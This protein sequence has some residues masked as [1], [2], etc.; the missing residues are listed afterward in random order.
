M[1]EF[2]P[3][4][5]QPANRIALTSQYTSGTDGYVFDGAD[6][7][8]MA[9]WE[10]ASNADT[11]EHEHPFDEYFIVVEGSYTVLLDGN[12]VHVGAGQECFIPRGSRVAGRVT[13]GTRTIHMFGGPRARRAQAPAPGPKPA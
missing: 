12:E 6:G 2:P 8:Q 1:A 11:A 7:S 9:F 3:F 5:K 10:C 4:M 13:A